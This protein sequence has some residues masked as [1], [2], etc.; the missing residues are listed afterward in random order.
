MLQV[1]HC[2]WEWVVFAS[3]VRKLSC[4]QI[5]RGIRIL[6]HL[7]IACA[8]ANRSSLQLLAVIDQLQEV[9]ILSWHVT[10]DC[11]DVKV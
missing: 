7:L 5:V 8:I 6:D 3:R 4:M 10:N 9:K 1:I 2:K 11:R